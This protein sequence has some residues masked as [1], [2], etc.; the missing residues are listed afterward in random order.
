MPTWLL[1]RWAM[2]FFT[3]RTLRW[4]RPTMRW[5]FR[6]PLMALERLLAFSAAWAL[7][8]KGWARSASLVLRMVERIEGSSMVGSSMV[9]SSMVACSMVACSMVGVSTMVGTSTI[10]AMAVVSMVVASMEAPFSGCI[11]VTFSWLVPVFPVSFPVSPVPFWPVPFCEFTA[12]GSP[13]SSCW[14]YQ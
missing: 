1:P 7:R 13:G 4:L 14:L 2:A 12:T 6:S 8:R 3:E 5:A 9:G 11:L 10:S